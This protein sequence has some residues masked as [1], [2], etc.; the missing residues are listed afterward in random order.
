MNIFNYFKKQGL[1]PWMSPSIERLQ[2]G[3][4]GTIQM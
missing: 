3:Q 2:N 1:I 4:A